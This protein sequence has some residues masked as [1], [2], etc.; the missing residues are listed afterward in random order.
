MPSLEE[1]CRSHK[2]G[3]TVQHE[4]NKWTF[5]IWHIWKLWTESRNIFDRNKRNKSKG[6]VTKGKEKERRQRNVDRKMLNEKLSQHLFCYSLYL[7]FL[8]FF[9]KT[10]LA[11]FFKNRVLFPRSLSPSI[12][13]ST[14]LYHPQSPLSLSLSLS[15]SLLV[16]LS[17]ALFNVPS[18]PPFYFFPQKNFRFVIYYLQ[19]KLL[20]E[21]VCY[22]GPLH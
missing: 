11:I 8:F 7:F 22:R 4:A 5:C 16:L 15:V 12:S 6:R 19:E 21:S 18:Y 13:P 9:F 14:P 1:E 2:P 17:T 3:F 20:S 10:Y